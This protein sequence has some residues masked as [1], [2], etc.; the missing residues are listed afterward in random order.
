MSALRSLVLAFAS[1]SRIPM[2]HVEAAEEDRRYVMC[3]FPL[4]GV[5][6][7]LIMALWQWACDALCLGA[8][9]RGAVGAAL[10]L[11]VTGG[12]HMDGFMDTSDALAAW[13]TKERRL[14]ILKDSHVGA[15]AAMRAAVYLLVM[16]GLLSE[17][18]LHAMPLIGMCFVASRAMS[19][20]TS[21]RFVRARPNGML[22]DLA[23]PAR[24][25]VVEASSGLY[26]AAC[27]L[28]W[29]IFGGW[30]SALCVA[31]AALCAL[32]YRHMAYAKFGGITGDLAGWYLQVTEMSCI[33]AVILGGKML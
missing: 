1:F 32:A 33:A 4:V 24:M 17:T 14:E 18:E 25:C 7:A 6:V 27:T 12:I 11:L 23:R 19:A 3:F 2:P 28:V 15:F 26:I 9:L 22:D 10:P 30:I 8:F 21:V 16:A 29:A 31:A 13:Q 20:W 5:V